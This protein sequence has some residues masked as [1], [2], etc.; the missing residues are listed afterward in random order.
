M[1][2]SRVADARA[3]VRIELRVGW[4]GGGEMGYQVEDAA[5][6]ERQGAAGDVLLSD[7]KKRLD[8][9]GYGMPYPR[10]I[11]H[12]DGAGIID[13]VEDGVPASR[14][15]ERVWCYG[16]QSYRPFGT[17]AEY[18]TVPSAQA[19][20]LPGETPFEAAPSAFAPYNWPAGLEPGFSPR[21]VR[22]MTRRSHCGVEP[23][24]WSGRTAPLPVKS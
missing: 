6:Y 11:P 2:V 1:F 20:P 8:A 10:V 5:W 7:L 9:Y 15:G 16:A 22:A 3:F 23:M 13:R 4:Q 19:V 12:S 24:T 17:A 18:V 21:C 14:I